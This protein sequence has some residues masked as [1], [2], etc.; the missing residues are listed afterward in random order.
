VI[1]QPMQTEQNQALNDKE[2]VIIPHLEENISLP[3]NARDALPD[4]SNEEELEM[5][6]NTIKLMSDLTGKPIQATK[7]DIAEAKTVAETMVK[8]PDTKLQLKK[9]KNS[10]LASL[11]GMVAELDAQVVDDLKDLKTFVVN[12]L[13]KEAA[14]AEKSKERITALRA[15]G[16]VD[17]VDAFKKT[18]EVIHK[19]MS[20]DDIEDKLR[21]LVS[22][23]EKRV[24]EKETQVIDAE[25]VKDE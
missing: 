18:T 5:M 25:I 6:V 9:Y 15:I 19:N 11:A 20:L 14:T 17:G 21:T 1:Q 2:V 23:I 8:H 13:I 7:E 4:L 10:M 16:E 3:R 12:G 22:R 24:Q